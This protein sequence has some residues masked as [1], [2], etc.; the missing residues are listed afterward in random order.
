MRKEVRTSGGKENRHL[1]RVRLD[2]VR[3]RARAR[4]GEPARNSMYT[5]QCARKD[6]VFVRC[7]L[8]ETI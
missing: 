1:E 4:R 7:E 5:V 3:A 6:E 8:L 2:Y